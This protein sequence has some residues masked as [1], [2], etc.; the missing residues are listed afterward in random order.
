MNV[1]LVNAGAGGDH[2]TQALLDMMTIMQEFPRIEDLNISI[3]G[4]VK[5]SR[6][7]IFDSDSIS[8][9]SEY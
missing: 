3:V 1:A 9:W 6:V 7:M 5:H 2:P 4:D 8:L